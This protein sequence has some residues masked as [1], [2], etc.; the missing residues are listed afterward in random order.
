MTAS[1]TG[2]ADKA[3][4]ADTV[5]GQRPAAALLLI[6]LVA[7]LVFVAI[8]R[9]SHDETGNVVV[10]ALKVA[11]PFLIAAVLGWLAAQAWRAPTIFRT[12][13]I[14]WLCTVAAGMVLRHFVFNRGTAPAFVIVATVTLCLFL[15]GW[16]GVANTLIARRARSSSQ[17]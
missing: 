2:H 8:G 11:A 7:V 10:G 13:V 4:S 16:R 3:G 17:S 15:V 14:V 6:D 12:G 5:A 1:S 9:R